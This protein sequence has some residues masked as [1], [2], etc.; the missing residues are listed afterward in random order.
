M[1]VQDN[2]GGAPPRTS[3][4]NDPVFRGIIYQVLVAA[5]VIGFAAWIVLNTAQNLAMQNKTTG[6]DFLFRTAGFDISFTLFPW[7][8]TSLYWQAFVAGLLN[9]LLVAVIG[10]FFAT[11]IGFTLGIARLS[12][13]WL[14]SRVATVYIE[15]IRNIPLLLQLFFWYFAVLKAMPAVRD[16]FLLPLGIYINQRGIMVP[17]PL[18]D[19]E[20]I[21]VAVAFVLCLVAAIAIGVWATR[22]RTLTGH[23]PSSIVL[24][25]RVANAV[26]MFALG[27]LAFA[28][29]G[30]I[31][32][33]LATPMVAAIAAL[34]LVAISFTPYRPYA[35][36][37]VA[38][39]ITFVVA[40]FLLGGMFNAVPTIAVQLVALLIGLAVG[41]MMLE[42][43]G[44]APVDASKFPT[45]LPILVV[46]GI[47]L[48]LYWLIGA[49]LAFEPPVLQRFN[50]QGGVQLPP[51][52]VALVFGLSIYTAAFI[53]E[54]VRGGIRAVSHGQ[55]EA[56][57][58]LGL[59]EGDRLRLVIV[60]QAMRV[61]VP[62]LTSQYLNLTKNSSLGAA[63]G[64]PELVNVFT[65]TTLNQTGK[66][67]EVIALTMA[68]Y[69]TFSLVTSAFMNWYNG[70]VALVER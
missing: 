35:G 43:I 18:P 21:W 70:R 66:A 59:K 24:A 23:Y 7:S 22:Q 36:A 39:A 34:V 45:A 57:Q 60:P 61:I 19:H 40:A 50:F 16:S 29:L 55:T 26:V 38:S 4:L 12:S 52:L 25:A 1:A 42:R 62:P 8:R 6:F 11:I 69:L 41:W 3:L 54:N 27:Y 48:V 5:A 63:I 47:P 44:T 10:I 9:T 58:S 56:A 13:N 30:Q 14:I 15:T 17:K 20:F 32:P 65:G 67:I 51:E 46:V 68:V 64:Y 28:L 53:A 37:F 49:E 2:I 33:G 31:I